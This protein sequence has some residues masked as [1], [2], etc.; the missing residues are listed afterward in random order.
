MFVVALL[1]TTT[2]D[3]FEV[4]LNG[5]MFV[6]YKSQVICAGVVRVLV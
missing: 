4:F 2:Y 3:T 6:F 5:N 1:L